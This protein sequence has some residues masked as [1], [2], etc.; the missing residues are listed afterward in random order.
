MQAVFSSVPAG[1]DHTLKVLENARQIIRAEKLNWQSAV[2][3]ELAAVLHDIGALE[4]QRK[5][6]RPLSGAGKSC[7]RP[8]Y[9]EKTRL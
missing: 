2:I 5:H 7:H 9:Y 3:V 1:I 6:G 8:G 4:A